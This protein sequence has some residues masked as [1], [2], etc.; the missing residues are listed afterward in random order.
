MGFRKRSQK[1]PKNFSNKCHPNQT[2]FGASYSSTNHAEC[3]A[4]LVGVLQIAVGGKGTIL[5]A[6]NGSIE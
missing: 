3:R 5:V 2:V 4:G 1:M 6:K